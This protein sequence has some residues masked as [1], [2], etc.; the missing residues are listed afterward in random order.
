MSKYTTAWVTCVLVATFV[1]ST[2][3]GFNWGAG[4]DGGKGNFS[5]NLQKSATA[6][7]G[8]IPPGK[9]NVMITLTA[10]ADAD[11]QL[12]DLDDK[13]KFSEGRAIVAW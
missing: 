9:W 6:D 10:T 5:M 12:Y 8:A 4:C 1:A 7:V 11:V 13:S 2:D 3:A